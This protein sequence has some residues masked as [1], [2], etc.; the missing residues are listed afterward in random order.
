[1][2]TNVDNFS[3][4]RIQILRNIRD[5]FVDL[6]V[7]LARILFFWMPGGDKA[8]GLALMACHP[9]FI[10][11]FVAYFFILPAGHILRI[12]IAFASVIVTASQ[13]ML[14]GCVITRAEQRLTGS[15]NTIMDPFLTFANL[16]ANRNTRIAITIGMGTSISAILIWVAICDMRY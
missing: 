6:F 15:K 7:A 16:P 3:N 11:L 8:Q 5:V 4:K 1:M 13:W 2:D 10:I 12:I 14:G 9:F